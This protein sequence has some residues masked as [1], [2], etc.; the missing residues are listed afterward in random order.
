MRKS[1]KPTYNLTQ[2][3]SVDLI[4]APSKHAERQS[5][6]KQKVEECV[7]SISA[8]ADHAGGK[9]KNV[10]AEVVEI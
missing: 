5:C 9:K 6:V 3:W 7:P 1:G 10:A 8:D 2:K 4:N